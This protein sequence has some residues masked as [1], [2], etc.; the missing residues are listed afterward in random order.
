MAC[1]I[2]NYQAPKRCY[3]A[4]SSDRMTDKHKETGKGNAMIKPTLIVTLA[5]SLLLPATAVA[6]QKL[7]KWVDENGVTHYSAQPPANQETSE[8]RVS[9]GHSE[10]TKAPAAPASTSTNTSTSSEAT[11]EQAAAPQPVSTK[12]KEKCEA[13]RKNIWNLENFPRVRAK[14]EKT[15]EIRYLTPEEHQERLNRAKELEKDFC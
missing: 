1:A 14:D 11:T 15:G 4:K 5:L 7:Y 13:T 12:D 6:K 8:I 10:P 3:L 2:A 9:T